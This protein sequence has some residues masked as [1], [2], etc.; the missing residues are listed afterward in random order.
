MTKAKA[1]DAVRQAQQDIALEQELLTK[2]SFRTRN[3]TLKEYEGLP[4]GERQRLH[5]LAKNEN[6]GWI[7]ANLRDHKAAWIAVVDG[8]VIASSNSLDDYPDEAQILEICKETGKFP[9]IFVNDMILAIEESTSAWHRTIYEGD[10]Y[11]TIDLQLFDLDKAVS[12]DVITDFDTGALEMYTDLS[13]LLA[14][15]IVKETLTDIYRMAFHLGQRYVYVLKGAIIRVEDRSGRSR[16]IR[17]TLVCVR[18][19]QD[20]PF[21]QVNPTRQALVG[22]SVPC[23]LGACL[24]L[25]FVK[26]RTG[27]DLIKG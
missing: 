25:D 15:K 26:N 4:F 27:I 16:E 5:N 17:K 14:H 1:V 2:I 12:M 8:R 22:R 24:R 11:P 20:G 18:D 21:V 7:E 6:K 13:T 9:F 10:W 19:W 3:L 23:K